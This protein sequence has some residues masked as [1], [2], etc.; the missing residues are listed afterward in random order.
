MNT[1][2]FFSTTILLLIGGM[3]SGQNL[4]PN[5]DFEQYHGCPDA[6]GQ[7]DSAKFWFNPTIGSPDYYNTCAPYTSDINIPNTEYGFQ[8][9]HSGGAFAGLLL[10]GF[11][12]NGF[13]EYI[14]VPLDSTLSNNVTYYFE[15]YV[16]LANI[17]RYTI[18]DIGVYFSNSIITGFPNFTNLP[19]IPQINNISGNTP[20]TLNWILISGSYTAL[21]GEN[22][23]TIGNFKDDTFLD[24]TALYPPPAIP[25]SEDVTYVYVDDISLIRFLN[26]KTTNHL[27]EDNIKVFPNPIVDR[28]NITIANN[29][30]SEITL[31]DLSSRIHF[32]ETFSNSISIN[33]DILE[34]GMYIYK[35]RSKNR[36][37]KTGKIIKQ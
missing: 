22:Y 15:M 28:L 16:N 3:C 19:F 25:P 32:Q 8:Q 33:T 30:L 13:R 29:E 18:S 37:I 6:F 20:D 17:S 35:V 27:N 24:T 23:L 1:V 26:T 31:F 34:K 4:V 7:I 10:W 9:A 11:Q 12:A 5:G 2:K 14:E 36:I 21:G